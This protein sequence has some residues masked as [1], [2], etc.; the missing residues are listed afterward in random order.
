MPGVTVNITFGASSAIFTIT[1][2]ECGLIDFNND[3]SYFDPQDIEACLSVCSEGSCTPP[4]AMCN[5]V[6]INND[7][8]VVD[9]CDTDSLLLV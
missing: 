3:T 4:T 6:D 1:G 9:P 5:E 2:T 8:S 7:G